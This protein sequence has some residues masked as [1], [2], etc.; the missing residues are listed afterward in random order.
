MSE[1]TDI[2]LA[3]A[4]LVGILWGFV[5]MLARPRAPRISGE[6]RSSAIAK[7]LREKR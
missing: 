1:A 5:R 6:F 2:V 7:V 3:A 4:V